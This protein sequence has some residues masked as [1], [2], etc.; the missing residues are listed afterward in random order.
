MF[1][2]SRRPA[3]TTQQYVTWSFLFPSPEESSL[4][5]YTLRYVSLPGVDS[6]GSSLLSYTLRY[7]SLSELGTVYQFVLWEPMHLC[8]YV[9][10][11]G[12]DGAGTVSEATS[13]L[14][15]TLGYVSLPE[16]THCASLGCENR[17][18]CVHVW[19]MFIVYY[20]TI[21]WEVKIKPILNVGVMKD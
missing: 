19:T 20:E 9:S 13:L 15:Y 4:L 5:S 12:G 8:T 1:G 14:S 7:V 6:E 16:L 11:E 3:K 2:D 17:Y 21:K 10:E 18:T